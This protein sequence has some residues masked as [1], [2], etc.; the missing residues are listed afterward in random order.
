[1]NPFFEMNIEESLDTSAVRQME[2]LHV[3]QR[4][5]EV[6]ALE[7]KEEGRW[8]TRSEVLWASVV[9]RVVESKSVS[10]SVNSCEYG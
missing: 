10:V 3:G 9:E 5:S 2:G 8:E 1:M 4:L 6:V 7:E